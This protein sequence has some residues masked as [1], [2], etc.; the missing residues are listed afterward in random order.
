MPAP[1]VPTRQ[2]IAITDAEDKIGTVGTGWSGFVT[3]HPGQGSGATAEPGPIGPKIVKH[4]PVL[5]PTR[6]TTAASTVH[7]AV[8]LNRSRLFLAPLGRP[9]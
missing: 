2:V 1:A 6:A 8:L 4:G 3:R 9:G 7:P 5:A